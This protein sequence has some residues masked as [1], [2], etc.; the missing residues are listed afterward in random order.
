MAILIIFV[1]L[2][3]AA[4]VLTGG[5]ALPL[6]IGLANVSAFAFAVLVAW[7]H[8]GR[9]IIPFRSILSMPAYVL[10]KISLYEKLL[11]SRNHVQHWV[12]TDR[13]GERENHKK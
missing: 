4:L 7:W 10:N 2:I 9:Q 8:F 12:R 1:N 11:L 6:I 13:E 3:S 5:P